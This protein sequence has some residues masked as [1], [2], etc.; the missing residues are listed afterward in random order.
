M[1]VDWKKICKS[2]TTTFNEKNANQFFFLI[3]FRLHPEDFLNF[4]PPHSLYQYVV[5]ELIVFDN[6]VE[7]KSDPIKKMRSFHIK[8]GFESIH[9]HHRHIFIIYQVDFVN[10]YRYSVLNTPSLR[11]FCLLLSK[12]FSILSSSKEISKSNVA[13]YKRM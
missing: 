6:A 10:L 4:S 8:V 11:W 9:H 13:Y 5:T 3:F 1:W 7:I 12:S 2:L